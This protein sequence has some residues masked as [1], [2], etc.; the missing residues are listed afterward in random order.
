MLHESNSLTQYEKDVLGGAL[1]YTVEK[2]DGMNRCKTLRFW[3]SVDVGDIDQWLQQDL[4]DIA[5]GIRRG[6]LTKQFRKGV[7]KHVRSMDCIERIVWQM[8][9]ESKDA[10]FDGTT[11]RTEMLQRVADYL[12][13]IGPNCL[14][15]YIHP[16]EDTSEE[17]DLDL[18]CEDENDDT[19]TPLEDRSASKI[20]EGVSEVLTMLARGRSQSQSLV[21]PQRE[22]DF[23]TE[24][25]ETSPMLE[26]I[27]SS[28]FGSNSCFL[29]DSSDLPSALAVFTQEKCCLVVRIPDEWI[30]RPGLLKQKTGLRFRFF[31][32]EETGLAFPVWSL[33]NDLVWLDAARA[34]SA[35]TSFQMELPTV[36]VG[37]R[38]CVM[39]VHDFNHFE[40]LLSLVHA[41]K[42]REAYPSLK[43]NDVR[44]LPRLEVGDGAVLRSALRRNA[45]DLRRDSSGWRSREAMEC[46]E[47][48]DGGLWGTSSC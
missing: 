48:A 8:K 20:C 34:A 37:S 17:D 36:Y 24:T 2:L 5:A 13:S 30:V 12:H 11:S 10:I 14:Y 47:V 41:E 35:I 31:D 25:N 43:E 32:S 26:D 7:R 21:A 39:V 19:L 29:I 1:R 45:I 4:P 3:A 38:E 15:S 33:G 16:G 28:P 44:E 27:R 9:Q 42:E 22:E 46:G 18:D 6:G 40:D 23:C